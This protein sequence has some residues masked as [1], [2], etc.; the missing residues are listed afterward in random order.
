MESIAQLERLAIA[1]NQTGQTDIAKRI[2]R[3]IYRLSG[4]RKFMKKENLGDLPK[5]PANL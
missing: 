4:S 1:K 3:R 5:V 2:W